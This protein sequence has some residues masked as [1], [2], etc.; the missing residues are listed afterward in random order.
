MTA[1]YALFFDSPSDAVQALQDAARAGPCAEQIRTA[2]GRMP[3]TG[4]DA[5]LGEVGQV[6]KEILEMDV[7]DVFARAWGRH[8]ALRRA[9]AESLAHPDTEQ[10]VDMVSHSVT[11]DHKPAVEIHLADLP[12]ARV[13]IAV[14]LEVVVKGLVAVL[15]AGRLIAVRAGAGE[16]TGRLSLGGELVTE[17]KLTIDLPAVI[18][19]RS[20]F[21]L[22]ADHAA[23]T[24]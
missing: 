23:R 10:L 17:R 18:N 1:V 16:A 4:K 12:V 19:L 11:I 6:A 3:Q 15:R 8:Q 7:S 22:L 2:L 21:P 5:V 20:G 24:H 13:A 14:H 9:A